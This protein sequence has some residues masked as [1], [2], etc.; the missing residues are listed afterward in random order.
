M[1]KKINRPVMMRVSR[2]EEY[3]MGSARAGFQGRIKMG[4]AADGRVTAADLYIV[5]ECGPNQGF[6]DWLSAA[7]AVSLVYQPPAMRFRGVSV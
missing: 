1:A 7:E 2:H 4:F 6:T 3:F 5:Q